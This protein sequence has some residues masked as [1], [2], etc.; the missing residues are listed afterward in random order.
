MS[1]RTSLAEVKITSENKC[2]LCKGSTCCTYVTQH[3]LTPRSMEDFD[4]LLWQVSH[5]GVSVY[6]DDE[7]WFLQFEGPCTH[8]QDDGRCA[9]Y[10]A[11]P[12]ICRTHSNDFCEFD[13]PAAGGFDLHFQTYESLLTYCRKRFRNW[14][15]RRRA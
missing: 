14:D 2:G 1:K 13:A 6:K 12:T 5:Q 4:M 8:L 10:A 11:R 7:G 9:I 3:L 15:R